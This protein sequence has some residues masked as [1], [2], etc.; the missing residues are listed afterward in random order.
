VQSGTADDSGD[1]SSSVL[2][3]SSGAIVKISARNQLAGTVESIQQDEIMAEV[4]V[5]LRGG[6]QV[7]SAITAQSAQRLG[8]AAGKAVVVIVKSTEVMLGTED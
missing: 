6:E 2:A 7:V 8:L 3:P 5:R 1:V 4:V